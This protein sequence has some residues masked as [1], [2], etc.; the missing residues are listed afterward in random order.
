MQNTQNILLPIVFIIILVLLGY[1]L[2]KHSENKQPHNNVIHHQNKF[3]K[4]HTDETINYKVNTKIKDKNVY[5]NISGKGNDRKPVKENFD[6]FR[7]GEYKE[8]GIYHRDENE[9]KKQKQKHKKPKTNKQ[10]G[11][12]DW[13]SIKLEAKPIWNWGGLNNFCTNFCGQ[14]SSKDIQNK[15]N[16]YPCNDVC[17]YSS[18]THIDFKT[19]K[20]N[21]IIINPRKK[22]QRP[23][24]YFVQNTDVFPNYVSN[25][26]LLPYDSNKHKDPKKHNLGWCNKHCKIGMDTH[27]KNLVNK[28]GIIKIPQMPAACDDY[29]D[30]GEVVPNLPGVEYPSN[31]CYKWNDTIS[32]KCVMFLIEN[33]MIGHCRNGDVDRLRQLCPMFNNVPSHRII[34]ICHQINNIIKKLGTKQTQDLQKCATILWKKCKDKKGLHNMEKCACEHTFPDECKFM[35]EI[36]DI[37]CQKRRTNR[38]PSPSPT[39]AQTF[40]GYTISPTPS[41]TAH[42]HIEGYTYSPTPSPTAHPAH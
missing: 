12:Q 21:D 7:L 23:D 29:C 34:K 40:E 17:E 32:L 1:F 26:K 6:V 28:D 38:Q 20:D 39:K 35:E 22:Q 3:K 15:M 36:I 2:T 18:H 4:E 27:P 16:M 8:N 5:Y 41:P 9:I 33:A 24:N 10:R 25:C 42:T 37:V 13:E 14:G 31:C 30:C 11:M 19:D